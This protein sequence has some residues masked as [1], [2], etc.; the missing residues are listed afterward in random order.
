[1]QEIFEISCASITLVT[2]LTLN[3]K[4]H[5]SPG[6]VQREREIQ[7]Q[8]ELPGEK[9]HMVCLPFLYVFKY[10]T[11]SLKEKIYPEDVNERIHIFPLA[12]NCK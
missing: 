6:E 12:L 9:Y 10:L 7:S 3:L 2:N 11:I 4:V 1:M 8:I 5:S